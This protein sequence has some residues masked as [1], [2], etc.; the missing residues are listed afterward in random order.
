MSYGR[1]GLV[2]YKRTTSNPV[3]ATRRSC[4][5]RGFL[6]CLRNVARTG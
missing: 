6:F 5:R 1:S 2:K 4:R 3:R